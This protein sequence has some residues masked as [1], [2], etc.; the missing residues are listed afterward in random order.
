[1]IGGVELLRAGFQ[2][3][4]EAKI[5]ATALAELG[6]SF[7]SEIQ[8]V[9]VEVQGETRRLQGSAETQYGEWRELLKEIYSTETGFL[10][11]IPDVRAAADEDSVQP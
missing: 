3:G 9:V 1:V 8:P 4:K 11:A 10:E 6:E 5:H 2:T 7:N